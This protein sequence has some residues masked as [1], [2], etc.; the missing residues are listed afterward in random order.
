MIEEARF[1][2][3]IE[4]M[5]NLYYST[6]SDFMKD[7]EKDIDKYPTHTGELYLELHRGTLTQMHD[8]KRGNRKAEYALRDAEYFNVLSGVKKDPDADKK[9]KKLL[10]NRYGPC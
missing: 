6:V 7:L 9:L 1:S 2:S 8:I 10:D 4:G 5:P 3:E